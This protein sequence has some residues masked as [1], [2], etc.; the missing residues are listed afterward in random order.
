MPKRVIQ[1]TYYTKYEVQ[2]SMYK[3]DKYEHQS[4]EFEKS[5]DA[6]IMFNHLLVQALED[7]TCTSATINAWSVTSND[8]DFKR[9]VATGFK[10]AY[11]EEERVCQK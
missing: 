1:E 3:H 2:A 4:Y 8:L 7:P 9:S 10:K 6:T 11:I 5:V